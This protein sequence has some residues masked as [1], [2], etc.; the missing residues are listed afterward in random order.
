MNESTVY[1]LAE[2][3][4]RQ[5]KDAIQLALVLLCVFMLMVMVASLRMISYLIN[6]ISN[7]ASYLD[8]VN[9]EDDLPSVFLTSAQMS[10]K[11]Q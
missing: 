2:N 4:Q 6:P 5:Q 9:V 7:L 3:L 10:Q 8:E 11:F 1:S